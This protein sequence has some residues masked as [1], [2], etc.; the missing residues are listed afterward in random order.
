MSDPVF[1]Q[2]VDEPRLAFP[3]AGILPSYTPLVGTDGVTGVKS[4]F[5]GQAG[6]CD[7]LALQ[8]SVAGRP[9]TVFAAVLGSSEENTDRAGQQALALARVLLSD[10]TVRAIATRGE[11]AGRA[12]FWGEQV[13]IIVDRPAQVLALGD[14]AVTTTLTLSRAGV[15]AG[16]RARTICGDLRIVFGEQMIVDPLLTSKGISRPT[17]WQRVIR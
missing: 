13:P 2:I 10:V 1:A 7:V 15:K 11:V 8:G 5:T 14:Q 12:V 16:D 17:T 9:F 3:G 4:G 6:P